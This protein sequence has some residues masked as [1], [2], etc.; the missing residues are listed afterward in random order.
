MKIRKIIVA[1]ILIIVLSFLIG[2]F[3]Y[4]FLPEKIAS[5]WNPGGEVDGYA[6]K[7]LGIF[8]IPIISIF[9]YLFFLL[10]PKIDPLKKNIEK[11]REY[12]DYLI[13][14]IFFFLFYVFLLTILANFGYQFNMTKILIPAIG[15][16]FIYIGFI[17]NKFKRNWFIGI[18]TPW[19]LSSEHVWKNTHE[20]GSKLFKI[21]GVVIIAGVFFQ[22]NLVWFILIPVGVT[23]LWLVVYSYLEYR[24]IKH[25]GRK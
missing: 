10:I 21:S 17:L 6:G 3:S 11:F 23:V 8:L 20:L 5:H 25:A 16:L 9:L 22:D 19:T 12:Y 14:I 2:I 24:K 1:V 13:L 18:R 4:K 7:F 15:L